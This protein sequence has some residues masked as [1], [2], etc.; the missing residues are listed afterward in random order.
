M[1]EVIARKKACQIFKEINRETVVKFLK[2]CFWK[3]P[4]EIADKKKHAG[5]L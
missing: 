3:I 2:E 4:A 1:K 5:I